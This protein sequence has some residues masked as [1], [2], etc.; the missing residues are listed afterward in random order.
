VEEE[1]YTIQEAARILRTTERTAGS[2]CHGLPFRSHHLPLVTSLRALDGLRVD[3]SLRLVSVKIS[4]K[5]SRRASEKPVVASQ[6]Y[7]EARQGFS[8]LSDMRGWLLR[9]GSP[10]FPS[11]T[12]RVPSGRR[13]R[14]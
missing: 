11:N 8:R 14:A 6:P 3:L 10:R 1:T 5:A 7:C 2:F 12:T 13:H 4:I 9:A